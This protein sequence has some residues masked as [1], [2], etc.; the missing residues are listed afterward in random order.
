[1][2]ALYHDVGYPC[3]EISPATHVDLEHRVVDLIIEKINLGPRVTIDRVDVIAPSPDVAA[4]ARQSLGITRGDLYDA[5]KLED[6]RKRLVA[7]GVWS[8]DLSYQIDGAALSLKN[9]TT[10]IRVELTPRV[11]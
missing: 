3:V 10:T 1:L 5:T 9:A 11:D 6:A 7:S 2:R 8:V 4:R